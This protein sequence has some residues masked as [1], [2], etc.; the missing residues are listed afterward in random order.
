MENLITLCTDC[1]SVEQRNLGAAARSVAQA[2]MRSNWMV[3][4]RRQL[5]R[6]I[7]E[8]IIPPEDFSQLVDARIKKPGRT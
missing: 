4:H 8:A 3:K 5:Q 2:L 6:C 1:H 7:A